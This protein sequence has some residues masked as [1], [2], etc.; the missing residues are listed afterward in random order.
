MT[1]RARRVRRGPVDH[2]LQEIKSAIANPPGDAS[3]VVYD[4]ALAWIERVRQQRTCVASPT[5]Q[6]ELGVGRET[7]RLARE[8]IRDRGGWFDFD[9]RN[10]C[11]VLYHRGPVDFADLGCPEVVRLLPPEELLFLEVA[12]WGRKGLREQKRRLMAS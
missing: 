9:G 1:F 7:V 5:L 6:A 10:R 4:A 11:W 8:Y 3:A 12:Y 2:D